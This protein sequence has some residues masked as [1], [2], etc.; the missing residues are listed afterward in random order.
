[1]EKITLVQAGIGVGILT[2]FLQIAVLLNTLITSRKAQEREVSFK[3]VFATKESVDEV[4]NEVREVK[5][6]VVTLRQDIVQNGE[7][8]RI[9]IESKVEDSRK[10]TREATAK[11]GTEINEV[12]TDLA[13]LSGETEMINQNLVHLTSSV[14]KIADRQMAA[15]G[16]GV[17]GI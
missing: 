3:T 6:D 1:M 16:P 5:S 17:M 11:L 10:E 7:D 13:K 12:K 4:R 2:I 14:N 8:R 15:R 9:R